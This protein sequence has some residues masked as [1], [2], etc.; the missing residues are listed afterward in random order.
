MAE[1][2]WEIDVGLS[3]EIR[4][5]VGARPL[6]PSCRIDWMRGRAECEDVDDHPLVVA[7]PVRR[8]PSILWFPSHADDTRR[9]HRP[10]PVDAQID[11]VS[12]RANRG[13]GGI[14]A[15]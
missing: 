15:S 10:W 1:E 14:S 7:A 13:L 4:P 5:F 12:V 6:G 8:D 3:V 2:R 9:V 11:R